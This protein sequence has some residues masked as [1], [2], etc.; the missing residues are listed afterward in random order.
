MGS[1]YDEVAACHSQLRCTNQEYYR[2]NEQVDERMDEEMRGEEAGNA[3]RG[4]PSTDDKRSPL[5]LSQVDP[6]LRTVACL[7]HPDLR[8]GGR[9]RKS[10]REVV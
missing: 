2:M 10:F 4:R 3:S 5:Q 7:P 6:H 8:A 9:Q 1:V